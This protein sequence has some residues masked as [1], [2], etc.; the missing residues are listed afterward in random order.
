MYIYRSTCRL[1]YI[2]HTI[3]TIQIYIYINMCTATTPTPPPPPMSCKRVSSWI[4]SRSAGFCRSLERLRRIDIVKPRSRQ[5]VGVLR[6][7]RADMATPSAKDSEENTRDFS[8][9]SHIEKNNV[10][11]ICVLGSCRHVIGHTYIVYS[12]MAYYI[13]HYI[14]IFLIPVYIVDIFRGIIIRQYN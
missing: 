2:I 5:G 11:G 6:P 10:C 7:R 1:S 9:V 14:Y 8:G 4:R 3:H 13:L 12:N